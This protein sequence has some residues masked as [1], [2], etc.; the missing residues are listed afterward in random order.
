MSEFLIGLA[1][2]LLAVVAYDQMLG[3]WRRRV[4][5]HLQEAKEAI[6]RAN[7]FMDRR[8]RQFRERI[9]ALDPHVRTVAAAL[10]AYGAERSGAAFDEFLRDFVRDHPPEA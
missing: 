7:V 2:G 8:E 9:A 3:D 10:K 4:L 6:E 1:V 5:A